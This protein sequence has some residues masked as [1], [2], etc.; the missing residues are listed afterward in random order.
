MRPR[1]PY[2]SL[3]YKDKGPQASPTATRSPFDLAVSKQLKDSKLIRLH[4]LERERVLLLDFEGGLRLVLFLVPST[5]EALLV[6][7]PARD[8]KSWP[9]I[10]RSRTIRDNPEAASQ[11]AVPDGSRAPAEPAIRSE[12]VRPDSMLKQLDEWLDQEAYAAR[13]QILERSLREKTKTAQD[14]IRQSDVALAEAQREA[15]WQRYGD[16][17]K[18]AIGTSPEGSVREREVTDFETGEP[19][20]IPCDP[21][22][23]L[24]DQIEKFYQHARRKQRRMSEAKN[25]SAMF[26]EALSKWSLIDEDLRKLDPLKPDWSR[27]EKLERAMGQEVQQIQKNPELAKRK[28]GGWMGKAFDSRDGLPIWVGRSRDENLEL[29]FKHTR[30]NDI[31][32][33]VRGRPGSHVVIP[34][35]SGKSVPLETLLDAAN[36]VI[37][38]SGGESWGKTEVDYTF[39]KYVKRIKDS[40]E[41]SYTNNKTLLV[42]PD[43]ARLKRLLGSEEK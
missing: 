35:Q 17:L 36:L 40:T 13:I 25:R 20:R 5:P 18:G 9:V 37:Y 8:L 34:V 28:S 21:K 38:Y 27:L 12:L 2:F 22:L 41:A 32:M 16:L 15:D 39:K 29:T 43:R 33:H 26:G 1:H 4:A 24:R 23:G 14:R 10:T 7:T 42:E 6:R 31:W 30:G 3:Y 11:F 19:V